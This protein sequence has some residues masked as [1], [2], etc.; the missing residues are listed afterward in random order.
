MAVGRDVISFYEASE[1]SVLFFMRA[2]A[3]NL[4]GTRYDTRRLLTIGRSLRTK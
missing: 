4:T 1:A 3:V 2:V